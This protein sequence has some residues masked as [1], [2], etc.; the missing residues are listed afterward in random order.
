MLKIT[1]ALP[2][3]IAFSTLPAQAADFSPA[4]IC[5]AAISVEMGRPTKSMKTE[6]SSPYPVIYYKRPDGDSFKY[7]CQVSE[8]RVV[9]STFLTDTGEWGRWRKQYSE[10]DALTTYAVKNSMLTISN[11]QSGD[12]TFKSKDF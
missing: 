10:G 9:W 8:T 5:K 1:L 6:S 2:A 7:R 11:D 3:F 4:E 12:Q